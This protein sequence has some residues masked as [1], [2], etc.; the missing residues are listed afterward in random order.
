MKYIL[1]NTQDGLVRDERNILG[2]YEQFNRAFNKLVKLSICDLAV[3]LCDT[4][5]TL[6]IY[7]YDGDIDDEEI[8]KY[9]NDIIIYDAK[10]K[11]SIVSNEFFQEVLLYCKQQNK[12]EVT[13]EELCKILEKGYSV[14]L[15]S[16]EIEK[17]IA[18]SVIE[19]IN[20]DIKM[21]FNK[22]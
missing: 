14:T 3:A 4:F 1:V 18:P 6:K 5:D 12:V 17:D 10:Y 16:D 20:S 19:T 11:C 15:N 8:K 9:I 13:I 22:Y 7:E 2:V 21:F